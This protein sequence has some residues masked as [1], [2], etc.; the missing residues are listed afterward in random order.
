M[1]WQVTKPPK[2]KRHKHKLPRTRYRRV[3]SIAHCF[4]CGVRYELVES[5]S[6]AGPHKEWQYKD[7]LFNE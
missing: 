4:N 7:T 6:F 3:G 1:S 2:E 5:P